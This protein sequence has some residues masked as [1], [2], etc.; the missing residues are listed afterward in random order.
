MTAPRSAAAR[1]PGR[2]PATAS[3]ALVPVAT[4]A[5]PRSRGERAEGLDQ[6]GLAE[7]AALA[8]V[9]AVALAV[10]LVRVRGEQL[11]AERGREL[12]GRV[13]LDGRQ[14]VGVAG[15]GDDVVRAERA[16]GG[17]EQQRAVG[18]AAE[19]DEH[20]AELAQPLLEGGEPQVEDVLVEPG[21]ELVEAVEHDMG[22]GR[23]Q[24]LAGAAAGE[25]GDADDA[26]SEGTFDV[27]DVVAD[28][29]RSALARQARRP[30]R[31]PR[32]CP[33]GGRRRRRGGRGGS[34]ALRVNLPVTTT[35]RPP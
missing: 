21:R 22:A 28:V 5:M 35:V 24:L 34:W 6:L 12:A 17:R 2:K 30:C 16:Y 33:R 32:P 26:G 3:S 4:W 14:R 11:D 19:G 31:R 10:H 15:A 13:A 1:M 27:V 20:G 7:V 23:E 8:G 29:D 9:G 25:H 18:T